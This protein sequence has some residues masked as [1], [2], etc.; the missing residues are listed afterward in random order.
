MLLTNKPVMYVQCRRK[1]CQSGN[2]Y[3]ERVKEEVSNENAASIVDCCFS[4]ADMPS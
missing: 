1:F 4:E 3:V 2:K